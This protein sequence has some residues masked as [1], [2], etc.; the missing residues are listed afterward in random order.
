MQQSPLRS[1]FF[2]GG[3]F[4]ETVAGKSQIACINQTINCLCL[5]FYST[6]NFNSTREL[7]LWSMKKDLFFV[8][9]CSL[10]QIKV[11]SRRG[12][13][14]AE[15]ELFGWL[16]NFREIFNLF[17]EIALTEIS[18]SFLSWTLVWS[19]YYLKRRR[20][21][22]EGLGRVVHPGLLVAVEVIRLLLS[23]SY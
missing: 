5:S 17:F 13:R 23:Q 15:G 21:R 11:S 3:K 4:G 8:T 20:Y 2:L 12:F 1:N 6:A 14:S 22:H 19:R 9:V 10:S 18:H 7:Y 16:P